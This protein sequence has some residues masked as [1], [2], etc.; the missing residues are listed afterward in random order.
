MITIT[1]KY[2]AIKQGKT[3]VEDVEGEY[4]VIEFTIPDISESTVLNR[5]II[6]PLPTRPNDF[7]IVMTY[8]WQVRLGTLWSAYNGNNGVITSTASKYEYI[9]ATTKIE[10]PKEEALDQNGNFK[11]GYTTSY[12]DVMRGQPLS[13]SGI[14]NA[15]MPMADFFAERHFNYYVLPKML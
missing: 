10:V 15:L 8:T 14:T 6:E 7:Q 13:G 1:N 2:L 12:A 5:L 11:D 9:N 3:F 4:R